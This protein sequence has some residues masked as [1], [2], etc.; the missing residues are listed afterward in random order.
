MPFRSVT[1]GIASLLSDI[2]H[3]LNETYPGY[4]FVLTGYAPDGDVNKAIRLPVVAVNK[5][6]P[7]SLD[8][9]MGL[10]RDVVVARWPDGDF[11]VLSVVRKDFR[12]VQIPVSLRASGSLPSADV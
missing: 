8:D 10:V 12:D 1:L 9:L 4:K 3:E 6:A 7:A 2:S 5:P 11:A